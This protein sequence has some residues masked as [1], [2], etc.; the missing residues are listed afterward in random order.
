MNRTVALITFSCIVALGLVGYVVLIL[1]KAGNPDQFISVVLLLLGQISVAAGTLWSLGRTN[2]KLEVVKRQT[3]GA[4]S[5]VLE[6]NDK[7]ALELRDKDTENRVLREILRINE[8]G[9]EH[10]DKQQSPS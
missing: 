6:R 1:T 8:I 4:L 10:D 3:N 7:Q 2:D 5:G 9:T